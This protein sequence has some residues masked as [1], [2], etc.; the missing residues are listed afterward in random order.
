V[1]DVLPTHPD[2]GFVVKT[3]VP[4]RALVAY[5]DN[6]IVASWNARRDEHVAKGKMPAN[7][8]ATGAF[9]TAA[10]PPEFTATWAFIL[11]PVGEDRTRLIERFRVRFGEA[12]PWNRVGLPIMGFGVF[13]MLR[14]QML[15]IKERAE[16]FGAPILEVA[17]TA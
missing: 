14:K 6:E 7:L 15:G 12:R 1:G 4:E 9:M 17:P 5:L 8:A 3:I 10:Q 11:Q 2:G 16:R 13:V